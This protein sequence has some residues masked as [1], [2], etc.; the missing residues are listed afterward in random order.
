MTINKQAKRAARSHA[1]AHNLSYTAARRALAAEPLKPRVH[2]GFVVSVCSAVGGAGRTSLAVALAAHRAGAGDQVLIVDTAIQGSDVARVLAVP[3]PDPAEDPLAALHAQGGGDLS[4]WVTRV[5]VRTASGQTQTID[6]LAA[7]Q[8]P[9]AGFPVRYTG[10]FY[11]AL[12]AQAR[13]RYDTIILDTPVAEVY[14]DLFRQCVHPVSDRIVV[15]TPDRDVARRRTE[16]WLTAVQGPGVAVAAHKL[17]QV[18]TTPST[19]PARDE[20][21]GG[22]FAATLPFIDFACCNE[23]AVDAALTQ[24]WSAVR[25]GDV[26]AAVL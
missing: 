24:L 22:D 2:S 26:S 15:L 13:A 25:G 18:L 8:D 17:V 9:L 3:G 1:A 23:A 10:K 7:P 16:A 6:L 4:S 14:H 21:A 12:I 5:P 11:A 20:G 19:G